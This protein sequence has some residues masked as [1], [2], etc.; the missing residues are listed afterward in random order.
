MYRQTGDVTYR[1]RG[2]AIFA[3]GVHNAYLEPMKQFDQN[4]AWSFDY[5]T[6]RG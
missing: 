4:Y 1:D 2:D 5:L 6:Y 3:G